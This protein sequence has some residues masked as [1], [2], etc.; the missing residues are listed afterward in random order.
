MFRSS[1]L[2]CV[3]LAL[4][5]SGAFAGD[6][7]VRGKVAAP[8]GTAINFSVP[9]QLLEAVKTSGISALVQDKD[10]FNEIVDSLMGDLESIK[11]KNLVEISMGKMGA[12]VSVEEAAEDRPEEANFIKVDVKPA[13]RDQPEVHFSLPKGIFFLGAFIGNQLMETYGKDLIELAKQH[14]LTNCMPSMP[15]HVDEGACNAPCCAKKPACEKSEKEES[16]EGEKELKS[17]E[18]RE[19]IENIDADKIKELILEKLLK[20][21]K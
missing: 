11:G 20:E 17:E 19:K 15:H 6:L 12:R 2:G 9:V 1:I 3:V 10:K 5:A 18:I 4:V 8:D 13:E 14:I 7:L 16:G 21:L